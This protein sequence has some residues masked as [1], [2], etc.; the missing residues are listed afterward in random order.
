MPH[1]FKNAETTCVRLL[2]CRGDPSDWG[3][4]MPIII[5][6]DAEPEQFL[7]L[8]KPP[9]AQFF[10]SKGGQSDGSGPAALGPFLPDGAG[11]G[12]LGRR[13]NGELGAVQV[14]RLPAKCSNFAAA[15]AAER[16]RY[17]RNEQAALASRV[18]DGRGSRRADRLDRLT[19]NLRPIPLL[20]ERSGIANNE[21]PALGLVL[22]VVQ[23]RRENPVHMID[24]ARGKPAFAV[25]PAEGDSLFG[26]LHVTGLGREENAHIDDG[27]P[28]ISRDRHADA[29]GALAPLPKLRS[30]DRLR[31]RVIVVRCEVGVGADIEAVIK[32]TSVRPSGRV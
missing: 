3:D 23:C 5:R 24:S 12:L 16:P 15:Q 22:G 28:L 18:Q 10:H 2:G 6:P 32:V 19:L 13:N 8:G 9:A 26:R 30:D 21:L 4:D 25:A 27:P 29:R 14:D 17:Q 1:S 31:Q 7:C 11:V 20:E